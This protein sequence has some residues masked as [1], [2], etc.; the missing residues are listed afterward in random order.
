MVVQLVNINFKLTCRAAVSSPPECDWLLKF[1]STFPTFKNCCC[2]VIDQSVACWA[3]SVTHQP[4]LLN[5]LIFPEVNIVFQKSVIISSDVSRRILINAGHW[6]DL[7]FY[8]VLKLFMSRPP[9]ADEWINKIHVLSRSVQCFVKRLEQA[10]ICS[11]LR[12]FSAE[13]QRVASLS[14]T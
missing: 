9:L 4:R 11:F 12:N 6:I 2:D 14:N 3:E 10:V 5:T 13:A 1:S 7:V 8:S